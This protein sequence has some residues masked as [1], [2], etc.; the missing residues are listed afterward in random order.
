MSDWRRLTGEL[1]G[2][3]CGQGPR[4]VFVHGVTQTANSWKPVAARF[5][6]EGYESIVVDQP[7]H[8]DSAGVHTDLAA[9]AGLLT[10]MC[11][12][13]VYVGYSM[14]GRLC[15]HAAVMHPQLVRGVALVGATAGIADESERSRRRGADDQLA[16]TI[17]RI[18][19]DAFLDEWLAQPLF[20]GLI[21]DDQQ[22]ADRRRNSAGGLATSLRLAGTGVQDSLWSRLDELDMPVLAIAGELDDKYAAIGR[23]LAAS[24]PDG[25]FAE[26]TGAGHAAHLQDPDQLTDL[27]RSWLHDID[28]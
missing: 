27:L 4:M 10:S 8:G 23:Q 28:W 9:T 14:G 12:S 6:A 25:R 13:A 17:E 26:I 19:V 22:R 7:G 1:A 16:A 20:A 15:L 24:V 21:V 11:G 5:A 2:W 18:G 3:T